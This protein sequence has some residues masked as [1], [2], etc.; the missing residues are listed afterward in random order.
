MGSLKSSYPIVWGDLAFQNQWLRK[1]TIISLCLSLLSLTLAISLMKRKPQFVILG[2]QA[3]VV[4]A[5]GALS[6]ESEVEKAA[7]KYLELRYIWQPD[8]Q[9]AHLAMAK[10]FVAIP[11]LK[12]FEKTAS[13]LVA[14]SNGKNVSQRIYPTSLSVD[15][16]A[17]R[18]QVIADRFTEIQGLKATTILRVNL[19]YQ[20]GPRSLENPWGIFISKE[21]EVQ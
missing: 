18:I 7:R 17:N 5:D 16:K 15:V 10:S 8:D 3:N 2:A 14:F 11:S 9:A 6:L 4:Q 13:E 20:T 12:A 19:I 21:E 1:I